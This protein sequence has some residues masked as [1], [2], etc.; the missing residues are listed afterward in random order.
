MDQARIGSF[1]RS[2]VHNFYATKTVANGGLQNF[3]ES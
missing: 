1:F 2:F 3:P